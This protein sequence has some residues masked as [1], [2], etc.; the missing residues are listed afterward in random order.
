M[1]ASIWILVVCSQAVI[2]EMLSVCVRK[3]AAGTSNGQDSLLPCFLFP[4][5]HEGD[6]LLS[7]V[8]LAV[9]GRRRQDRVI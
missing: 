1:E 6:K 3:Q 4:S 8:V 5:V 2:G 9:L 7:P